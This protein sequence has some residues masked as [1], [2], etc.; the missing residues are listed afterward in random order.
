MA[1][2]RPT[3]RSLPSILDRLVD[4]AT[5]EVLARDA[6]GPGIRVDL[7]SLRASVERD[8]EALLNTRRPP[9][10]LSEEPNEL[11]RSLANYGLPDLSGVNLVSS[12]ARDEFRG[13]VEE[14]V[15]RFEPRFKTVS[16]RLRDEWAEGDRSLRL[17]IE[18]TLHA[19]PVPETVVFD[20]ILEPVARSIDV[21]PGSA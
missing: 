5:W 8:L 3:G 11:D 7:G 15:R 13:M 9:I 16:V 18:G 4:E 10:V 14:A 12:D 17:R 1:R 2:G 21:E 19:D 20:S 6:E